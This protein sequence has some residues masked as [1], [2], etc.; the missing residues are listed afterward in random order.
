[1][2]IYV[3][4]DM[5]G[6]SGVTRW[7]DVVTSGQDYQGA[8]SWMTADVNAAVAGARAAGAE[9]FMPRRAGHRASARTRSATRTMRVS[10]SSD[11][12]SARERSS[13]PRPRPRPEPSAP[14]PSR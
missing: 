8:R 5:E 2:R 3:S 1:M 10:R 7:Q 12:R 14:T 6:I 9:E 11:G 13:P 4:V